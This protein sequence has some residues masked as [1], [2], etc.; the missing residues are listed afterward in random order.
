MRRTGDTFRSITPFLPRGRDS[1][2]S[3]DTA[4]AR[5]QLLV[6]QREHRQQRREG[7]EVSRTPSLSQLK[8]K[9]SQDFGPSQDDGQPPQS[10]QPFR[11]QSSND[12]PTYFICDG[13]TLARAMNVQNQEHDA[14]LCDYCVQKLVRVDNDDPNNELKVCLRCYRESCYRESPRADFFDHNGVERE[15]CNN[16]RLPL[17]SSSDFHSSQ[18][19]VQATPFSHVVKS[20]LASQS[21][22][23]PRPS[24]KS[25]S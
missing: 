18:F 12:H 24:T 9:P 11:S 2:D 1:A 14:V 8:K 4:E 15:T 6:I 25:C 20:L 17:P 7:R 23:S 13:C 16:C 10:A 5:R 3:P 21:C 22:A 19:S